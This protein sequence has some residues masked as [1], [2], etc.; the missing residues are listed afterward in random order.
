MPL[1][2]IDLSAARPPAQRRAI[3]DGVHRALVDAIGIPPADRFQIVTPHA[4]DE[5]IFDP[6]YLDVARQDVVSIQIT[7][8]AGRPR[9]RKLDLFQRI[10]ENLVAAGVRSEDVFVTLV[11]NALDNWSVGHGRAQLVELGSVAGLSDTP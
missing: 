6:T 9:E 11:E 10:T 1:V 2:R 8:V 5:L 3:A 7:L 4:T